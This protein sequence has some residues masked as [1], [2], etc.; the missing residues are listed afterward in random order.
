MWGGLTGGEQMRKQKGGSI[1]N[2]GS[3]A[4]VRGSISGIAYSASKH[5]IIGLTKSTAKNFGAFGIRVNAVSPFIMDNLMGKGRISENHEEVKQGLERMPLKRVISLENVAEAILWLG[6][7]LAY[8]I[9]G[10][11]LVI[12]GGHLA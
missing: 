2:L 8:N 6:S 4:G 9:T 7:D 1:V 3:V 5:G 12:D 10:Q 11:N